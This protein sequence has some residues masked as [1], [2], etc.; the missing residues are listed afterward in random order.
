MHGDHTSTGGSG[1]GEGGGGF[2]ANG[3]NGSA[4]GASR[5]TMQRIFDL[6]D[7]GK[8]GSI[9]KEEIVAAVEHN[10]EVRQMIDEEMHLGKTL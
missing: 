10:V 9:S 6:I 7:T 1:S 4:G 8:N 3:A 2:G 5:A